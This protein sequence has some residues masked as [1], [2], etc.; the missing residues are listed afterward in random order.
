MPLLYRCR[1]QLQN[2]EKE[3]GRRV[4]L[5]KDSAAGQQA[6]AAPYGFGVQRYLPEMGTCRLLSGSN[7]AYG[8]CRRNFDN[9]PFVVFC[10]TGVKRRSLPRLTVAGR[11]DWVETIGRHQTNYGSRSPESNTR[12]ILAPRRL[13]SR[14]DCMDCAGVRTSGKLGIQFRSATMMM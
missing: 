11:R 4:R 7:C 1:F 9:R 13:A 12:H 8:S 2:D 14:A 6:A 5:F 3:L 10:N